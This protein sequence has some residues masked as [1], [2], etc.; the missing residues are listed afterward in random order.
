MGKH[1]CS[2]QNGEVPQESERAV[3]LR[4][5]EILARTFSVPFPTEAN[6]GWSPGARRL[7]LVALAVAGVLLVVSGLLLTGELGSGPGTPQPL[8]TGP[9]IT[10][11]GG[12]LLSPLTD[13]PS[14]ATPPATT[15]PTVKTVAPV[16]TPSPQPAPPAT[17]TPTSQ[18]AATPSQPQTQTDAAPTTTTVPCNLL[19]SRALGAQVP[20]LC[21]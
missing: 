21:R 12:Q 8:A 14:A 2:P 19:G 15:P 5:E 20:P 9:D 4:P 3:R 16:T 6:E 13:Q 1:A 10:T 11:P 18:P 7:F 17:G